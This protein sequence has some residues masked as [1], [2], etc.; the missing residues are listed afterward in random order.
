[1]LKIDS[2]EN[3]SRN[4]KDKITEWEKQHQFF[5]ILGMGRSGTK[6]L[7]NILNKAAGAQ[8]VHEPVAEDFQA[9]VEAFHDEKKA[10]EYIRLFRKKEIFYR[11][12][13]DDFTVYGEVNSV[14]RRHIR[15]L[16]Q[17]FPNA[18]FLHLVRDGRDVVRSMISRQTMTASDPISSRITPEVGDEY[19][20]Q[21]PYFTRFQKLSWYWMIENRYLRNQI[22]E[23]VQFERILS[24]YDYFYRAVLGNLGIEVDESSW[25]NEVHVPRNNSKKYAVPHWRDWEENLY[26][27]F[28]R[29][30]GEEM[31]RNGYTVE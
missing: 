6:F 8:V 27:E 1:M 5:F 24:D 11:T 19:Y 26:A 18:V 12:W 20:D 14:L 29:I 2:K 17:A 25:Y 3:I 31:I 21:W 7:A 30:C 22:D 23:T 10:M 28:R 16:K 4:L 9:Y 13:Q 15:G